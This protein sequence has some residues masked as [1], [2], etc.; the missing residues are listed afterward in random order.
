MH[1]SKNKDLTIFIFFGSI[2]TR[3]DSMKQ[4]EGLVGYSL[5]FKNF[6]YDK[7]YSSFISASKKYLECNPKDIKI[8]FMRAKAYR[9][10]EKFTEAINDLKLILNIDPNDSHALTELYYIYYYTGMY[11]EALDLLPIIYSTRCINPYSVAISELVMRKALGLPIKLKLGDK[12]D[13]LKLQIV[14]YNE[15]VALEHTKM[16][17]YNF[18]TD[19]EEVSHFNENINIDYLFNAIREN[20]D[21][22]SRVNTEEIL[23]IHYLSLPNIGISKG[24]VCDYVKIVVVPNTNNIISI[25]PSSTVDSKHLCTLDFDY[26]KVYGEKPKVKSNTLSQIDKF[27]KRYGRV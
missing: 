22:A 25:Y 9:Q 10:L 11:D 19:D 8:L 4:I 27:Y 14:D 12:C 16:H 7:K 26:G 20:I 24:E 3:G 18:N 2:S 1:N 15:E 5:A 21:N 6:Y 13:Y 23:E 17:S